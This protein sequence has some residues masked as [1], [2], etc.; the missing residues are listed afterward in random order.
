MSVF[1]H[2]DYYFSAKAVA[3]NGTNAI[4]VSGC[5]TS[6][7]PCAAG[8]I[9]Y[10]NPLVPTATTNAY[11]KAMTGVSIPGVGEYQFKDYQTLY[12]A[13]DSLVAGT[14]GLRKFTTTGTTFLAATWAAANWGTGGAI[15]NYPG[16]VGVHGL[17]GRSEGSA[18]V[19]YLTS[20]QNATFPTNALFRYDTT[21]DSSTVATDGWTLLSVSSSAGAGNAFAGGQHCRTIFNGKHMGNAPN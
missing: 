20:S 17:A 10:S 4:L 15:K 21:F 16:Y 18:Y 19:L 7:V 1:V 12:A 9:Y 2:A 14:G 5:T 6:A 11:N 8:V 13:S 3:T